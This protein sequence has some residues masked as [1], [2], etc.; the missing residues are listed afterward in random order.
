[1]R[2]SG[3]E[4]ETSV[5]AKHAKPEITQYEELIL[6][7]FETQP[8]STSLCGTPLREAARAA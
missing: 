6:L 3:G 5:A 7:E 4:A 2:I 8:Y 1:M